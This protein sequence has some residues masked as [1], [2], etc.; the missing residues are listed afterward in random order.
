MVFDRAFLQGQGNA[1]SLRVVSIP[2]YRGMIVDRNGQP[3]A[4][5]TPVA[6]V[7]IDPRQFDLS[8]PQLDKLAQVVN[9]TT[10]DIKNLVAHNVKREFVYLK[11]GLNPFLGNKIKNL[12]LPGI[13]VQNQF[14]RFYPEGEVTAQLVGLT[15]I[16]DQGQE[17]EELGFNNWL[18]GV[19]GKERILQ[20]RMGHVVADLGVIQ[21][22]KPGHDLA[23]SIDRR[24]Q[25]LAYFELE[26]AVKDT[27]AESGSVVVMDARTSEVLAMINDPSYNPNNRPKIDDGRFRNRVATDIFEPGSTIKPFS[28]ANAIMK[29]RFNPNTIIPIDHGLMWVDGKPVRDDKDFGEALTVTGV[30]QHSSNV[31]VTKMTLELPPNS[32]SQMLNSF[33]FGQSTKSGFPGEST[34]FIPKHNKLSFALATNAF[35]YGISV[36]SLQLVEAY[37]CLASHGIKRPISL[38]HLDK[39]PPGRQI[40]PKSVADEVLTMMRSVIE[41]GGTATAAAIPGYTVAGKT[42]TARMVGPH[43]YDKNHH[44][45]LFVGVAPAS[46]PRLIVAVVIKDPQG[47]LYHGGQVA[48]PVFAKIMAGALRIYNVPP[49]DLASMNK[50]D[51]AG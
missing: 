3:L 19:P 22:P 25:Y 32:L 48:A 47:Q 13:Y 28:V 18:A 36:T 45:A 2:A 43:G 40:L 50:N 51:K 23:L 1:R 49:D 27:G 41:T 12:N 38:V 11:R 7:W 15:N 33:G 31:G 35:G 42:G 29:G 37:A 6:S 14:H 34:G 5:S 24:I 10:D 30:L 8:S 21:R 20:D 46:A 9:V 17:G 16:D 4:V 39:P 26:R 44:V